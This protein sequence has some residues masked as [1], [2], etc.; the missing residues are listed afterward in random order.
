MHFDIWSIVPEATYFDF[1]GKLV[2]AST[3]ASR[4]RKLAVGLAA[5]AAA[6]E[7]G[8]PSEVKD[9]LYS[10]PTAKEWLMAH[11]YLCAQKK[12]QLVAL[13]RIARQGTQRVFD[14]RQLDLCDIMVTHAGC[15]D[16]GNFMR[17]LAMTPQGGKMMKVCCVRCV[18]WL[19]QCGILCRLARPVWHLPIPRHG[20]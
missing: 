4:K 16:K 1:T 5:A 14:M 8:C 12:V 2:P 3:A 10:A 7:N 13:A 9:L 6:R 17:Y 20:A 19:A 18:D 11:Q 15:E